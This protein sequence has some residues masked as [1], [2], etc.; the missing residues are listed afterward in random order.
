MANLEHLAIP[1]Q[2]V[3]AWN[4]LRQE[5]PQGLDGPPAGPLTQFL[6]QSSDGPGSGLDNPPY[7]ALTWEDRFSTYLMYNP[8]RGFFRSTL[9]GRLEL[10]R[11]CCICWKL[12]VFRRWYQCGFGWRLDDRKDL[13]YS[14]L[15]SAMESEGQ[16]K[17][18]MC[19]QTVIRIERKI[20]LHAM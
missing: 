17:S 13:G 18:S 12:A 7:R 3:E 19:P 20:N 4:R 11:E 8:E 10:V 6:Y 15:I 5:N 1:K 16:S 2:G 9:S 14:L